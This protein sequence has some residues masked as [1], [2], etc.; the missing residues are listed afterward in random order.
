MTG[1]DNGEKK[2][3]LAVLAHPDDESFGMG[4]TL[5]LYA[6]R[7]VEVHLVC[8]TRGE[9]GEVAPEFMEGFETVADLRMNELQCASEH[10]GLT[11]VNY[12]GYRDS[13]MTGSPDNE[14]PNALAAASVEEVAGRVVPYIRKL[15]PQVVLTF[16]P[17]GGYMHPDHIAIHQA[18][19][20]AF[21]AAGDPEQY[22]GEEAA[23]QAEKLYYHVI[24]R[25][26]LKVA[27]SL[28]RLFGQDPTRFGR[29]N[30]ID[31]VKLTEGG[32]FPV[33]AR[34]N[35]RPA[36]AQSEAA[37]ACHA[38]QLGGGP[39]RRGPIAWLLRMMRGRDTFMRAYPPAENGLRVS[40]LFLD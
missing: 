15:R 9:V 40:D 31:L 28:A 12:L 34:I 18:T 30:D 14:H 35:T 23:F 3:I 36:A 20:E 22:P 11:S 21:K 7:G 5:A 24:P 27:V 32:E 2:T 26:F 13:G 1:K 8:A 17:I 10:L 29:N 19:V 37:T 16:D 25:G 38:S 4:G 33:H 39:P 6:S